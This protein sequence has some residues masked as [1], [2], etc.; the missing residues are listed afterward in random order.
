MPEWRSGSDDEEEAI[1][2][3]RR[4]VA[5]AREEE[6]KKQKEDMTK[7]VGEIMKHFTPDQQN[8]YECYRRSAFGKN[9]IKRLMQSVTGNNVSHKTSI[10][11]AGV[12]K[13]FV[14]EI[15]ETAR[16]VME[17]WKETGPIRPRHLR[18]AYRRQQAK[19]KIPSSA[20][21]SHKKLFRK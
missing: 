6:K 1:A 5:V 16:T 13:I 18:E 3:R 2:K 17:E 12:T 7:M 20:T 19:G 10:V 9:A 21:Y 4:L 11:M 14:G 15:V 8:R